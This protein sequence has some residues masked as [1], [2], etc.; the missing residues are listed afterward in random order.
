MTDR[1]LSMKGIKPLDHYILKDPTIS[2]TG[3]LTDLNY[4]IKHKI[5]AKVVEK[6][7]EA[8]IQA[9]LRFARDEFVTDLYLIDREFIM[10]AIKN[11]MARRKG[12][13]V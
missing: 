12:E 1:E 9:I 6:T 8:L 3:D 7:D 11:E 5:L 10:S 2:Y 4:E 13:I